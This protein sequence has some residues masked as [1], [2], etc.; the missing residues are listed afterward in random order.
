MINNRF[1][2]SQNEQGKPGAQ[3]AQKAPAVEV[4]L[5]ALCG[6]NAHPA[7]PLL[8]ADTDP[9]SRYPAIDFTPWISQKLTEKQFEDIAYL[10]VELTRANPGLGFRSEYWHNEATRLCHLDLRSVIHCDVDRAFDELHTA[11]FIYLL[12]GALSPYGLLIDDTHVNYLARTMSPYDYSV[13]GLEAKVK[14]LNHFI[15]R[16]RIET[17]AV[18]TAWIEYATL[19]LDEVNEV[20]RSGPPAASLRATLRDASIGGRQLFFQTLED[21]AGHSGWDARPYGIDVEKTVQELV[22]LGLG[23][24]KTV[25]TPAGE[26]NIFGIKK[27]IRE[28]GCA[29]ASWVNANRVHLA[30]ALIFAKS[31]MG[32]Y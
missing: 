15:E 21:E 4:E 27:N 3:P 31:S 28:D 20:H 25:S 23:E 9:K 18:T 13:P 24:F 30:I 32:R 14:Y 2:R 29:L 6:K 5:C 26:Y 22:A 7:F 1:G 11:L 19:D 10:L 8:R 12:H 16:M 17:K